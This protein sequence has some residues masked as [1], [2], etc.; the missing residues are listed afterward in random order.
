MPLGRADTP[1]G[2]FTVMAGLLAAWQEVPYLRFGQF[3][4]SALPDGTDLF[5]VE[6]EV[7]LRVARSFAASMKAADEREGPLKGV[8]AYQPVT[9]DQFREFTRKHNIRWEET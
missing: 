7:L 8:A 4:V 3:L 5:Y 2:K 9:M 6:D 1:A